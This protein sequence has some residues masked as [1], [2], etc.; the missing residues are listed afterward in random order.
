MMSAQKNPAELIFS[1]EAIHQQ[2]ERIFTDSS[3]STS[4]ILRR[5]LSFVVE[6]T[7]AGRSN[8]IKEY[9]IG[10]QVLNKAVS[11]TPQLDAIVR[12]HA[13]RLRRAL[14]HY[15]KWVGALDPIHIS[16]PKGSYV[17]LFTTPESATIPEEDTNGDLPLLA[18][19]K[20]VVIAVLPFTHFENDATRISFAHGL[21]VQLS[22]ELSY[23]GN[24]SVIAY[25]TMSKMAKKFFDIRE[26]APAVGAQFVF[27]G[28]IQFQEDDCRITIQLIDTG[29]SEQ[30]WGKTYERK[31][32][33]VNMFDLQDEIVRKIM[34]IVAKDHLV[35]DRAAQPVMATVA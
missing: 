33:P 24:F 13:G 16:I 29:S 20:N 26:I 18:P 25:Y 19:K 35:F 31:F 6:E 11:Y 21:G 10:I 15:Y 32:S 14:H 7:L 9:T 34:S 4:N 3:F 5:F 28:D 30:V 2:L 23:S 1:G 12:I 17:P 27:T 8:T 22:T